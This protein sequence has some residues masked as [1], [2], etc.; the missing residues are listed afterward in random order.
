MSFLRMKSKERKEVVKQVSSSVHRSIYSL[1]ARLNEN[2][3]KV[4]QDAKQVARWRY[5]HSK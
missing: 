5:Q 4:L 2:S 3:I 1:G